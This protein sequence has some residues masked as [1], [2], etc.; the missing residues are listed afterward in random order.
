MTLAPEHFTGDLARVQQY[1]QT[2]S[3]TLAQTESRIGI[4]LEQI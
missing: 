1:T 2:N 4:K 3:K